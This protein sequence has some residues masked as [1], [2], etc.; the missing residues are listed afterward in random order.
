M[1]RLKKGMPAH[2]D[3]GFPIMLRACLVGPKPP[4]PQLPNLPLS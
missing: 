4:L 3:W 1:E 2:T